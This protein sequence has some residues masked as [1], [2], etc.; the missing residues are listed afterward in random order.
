MRVQARARVLCRLSLSLSLSDVFLFLLFY[1]FD[2]SKRDVWSDEIGELGRIIKLRAGT[3]HQKAKRFSMR[4]IF[5]MMSHHIELESEGLFL[6]PH[7]N[8]ITHTQ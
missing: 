2:F 4:D 5:E 6:P 1:F 8:T 3:H 7:N